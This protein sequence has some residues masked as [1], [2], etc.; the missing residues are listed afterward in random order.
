MPSD[1]ASQPGALTVG[2]DKLAMRRIKH[3]MRKAGIRWFVGA[4]DWSRNEHRDAI[5]PPRWALHV[6]GFTTSSDSKELRRRLKKRFPAT[7]EID[8]PIKVKEWDG[9]QAAGRYCL[10]STFTRR[11]SI[12]SERFDRHAGKT[13]P[14]R[15]TDK[16]PLRSS[17]VRE[18]LPHVDEL[19]IGGRISSLLGARIRN[20]MKYGASIELLNSK[21]RRR[22]RN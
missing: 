10:K 21:R 1:G 8:R 16:Q 15:N 3:A 5:F 22:G 2:T 7:T 14:C 19:G 13:R 18:L 11:I 20:D 17:E 6:H 12:E 4:S 9:N